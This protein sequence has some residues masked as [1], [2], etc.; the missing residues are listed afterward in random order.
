MQ[1]RLNKIIARSGYCSRRKAD[2]LIRQGKVKVNGKPVTVLGSTANAQKDTI[3]IAGAKLK[4]E[5]KLYILFHKPK[6]YITTTQDPHAEKKVFDLLPD[7]GARLFPVGRLDKDTSGLLILTNDG[8]F[9]YKMTHP[10]FEIKRVYEV[11]ISGVLSAATA[12]KIEKGGVPLE[13][14]VSSACKIT[15]LKQSQ[16]NTLLEL[17]IYE[18]RKREIRQIFSHF[19]H[20]VLDLKRVRFGNVKL[21]NLRA[22]QWRRLKD[23]EIL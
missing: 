18:G 16:N 14:H 11:E 20:N 9:A 19:G 4:T 6:G 23:K 2:E 22:G 7:F 3:T 5:E 8:E 13:K 15:I 21:A 1:E 12:A 17:S 10:K